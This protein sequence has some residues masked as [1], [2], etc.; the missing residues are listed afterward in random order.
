MA[1]EPRS[2]ATQR[3]CVAVLG[4][5]MLDRYLLGTCSRLAPEA[6]IP[7]AKVESI[8]SQLGG[9]GNVAASLA[10]LG[11]PISLLGVVGDDAEAREVRQLCEAQSIRS[12]LITDPERKTTVKSRVMADD[13]LVARFDSEDV[14]VIDQVH[15][16]HLSRQLQEL[17]MAGQ[18]DLLIVSDYMKG[19]CCP[20]LLSELVVSLG[21]EQVVDGRRLPPVQLFVDPK[22]A[23]RPKYLGFTL[24]KPNRNEAE[25]ILGYKIELESEALRNAA[26]K[27]RARFRC[28][29]LLLT[30]GDKGM[31]LD[32]ADGVFHYLPVDHAHRVLNVMG[33]G[34]TVM[35]AFVYRYLVDPHDL[36]QAA[37][38]ANFCAQRKVGEPGT[39]ILHQRDVALFQ[40]QQPRAGKLLD[41]AEA[42]ELCR[43]ARAQGRTVVFT[44]GCFDILHYG[45]ISMLQRC[46]ALG[47]V[48]IVGLNSDASVRRLKGPARPINSIMCRVGTLIALTSVDHVVVFHEDSPK[49]LLASLRPTILV[50]GSDYR[51]CDLE[52]HFGNYV[53]KVQILSQVEGLSTTLL[54]N[55][56]ARSRSHELQPI[57]TSDSGEL[58]SSS[59]TFERS[60]GLGSS[61]S[62]TFERSKGLG[63]GVV[64]RQ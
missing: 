61:S 38:F 50:K 53:E 62:H 15:L 12:F 33:A 23:N 4:D 28:E 58:S 48:L 22:D 10:A 49:D 35:A 54:L 30:L 2:E 39:C 7:I 6:P 47:D 55:Q 9:A 14:D 41:R 18:L 17:R 1:G 45:H 26:Q 25:A 27:L 42:A 24:V 37:R 36:L 21:K 11:V 8:R 34:D 64:D 52:A 44:N 32:T 63:S 3:R 40:A 20:S 46:R 51:L 59:H 19:V 16:D 5:V 56:L 57:N 13:K 31:V 29:I 43:S 60:K